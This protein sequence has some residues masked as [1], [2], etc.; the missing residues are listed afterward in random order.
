MILGRFFRVYVL[1]PAS[2]VM[3]ALAMTDPG[4]FAH[5]FWSSCGNGLMILGAVQFGYVAS[6]MASLLP[7]LSLARRGLW[8]SHP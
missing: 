8:A 1:F 2:G 3:I 5:S 4:I 7:A 6:L